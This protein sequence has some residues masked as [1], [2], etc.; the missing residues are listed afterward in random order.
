MALVPRFG[1]PPE[2]V[3]FG[4]DQGAGNFYRR[5]MVDI[6]RIKISLQRR[7][8]GEHARPANG[9]FL[10]RH[11]LQNFLQFVTV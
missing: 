2:I 9:A 4:R 7:I 11:Y 1:V 10:D 6:P 5:R 8:S 3:T